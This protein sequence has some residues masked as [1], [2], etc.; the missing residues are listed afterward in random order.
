MIPSCGFGVFKPSGSWLVEGPTWTHLWLG[1]EPQSGSAG[2]GGDILAISAQSLRGTQWHPG[3][4]GRNRGPLDAAN[5]S[6]TPAPHTLG[7]LIFQGPQSPKL[8]QA[9]ASLREG[10]NKLP[11]QR[12]PG[13]C[14]YIFIPPGGP[15]H[16]LMC[17]SA[18]QMSTDLMLLGVSGGGGGESVASWSHLT[19]PRT[20]L[21]RASSFV[22][23]MG[24]CPRAHQP[25][26]KLLTL[27]TILAGEMQ[28]Q[29]GRGTQ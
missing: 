4:E 11:P 10:E 23:A 14:F 28:A 13:K 27:S 20:E 15:V 7:F 9:L 19:S 16:S 25:A 12:A 26:C 3:G 18:Q 29:S 8:H 17:S 5:L 24:S 21:L 1:V 22:I 2:T 6:S